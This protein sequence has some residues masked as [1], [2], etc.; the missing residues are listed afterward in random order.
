MSELGKLNIGDLGRGLLV[1]VLAAVFMQLASALNTPGFDLTAYDWT[2]T[3]RIAFAAGIG[4]LGKN[5]I[6]SADGKILGK[7]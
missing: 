2:E 5:L 3:L 6:T 7:F 4:Y 1:A